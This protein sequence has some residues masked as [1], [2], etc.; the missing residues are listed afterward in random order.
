MHIFTRATKLTH[1]HKAFY[2][3]MHMTDLKNQ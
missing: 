2:D 3:S 1:S